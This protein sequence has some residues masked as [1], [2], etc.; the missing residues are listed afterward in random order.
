MN[1][2]EDY[3]DDDLDSLLDTIAKVAEEVAAATDDRFATTESII[4][5]IISAASTKNENFGL[6]GNFVFAGE[7]ID[8]DGNHH[9]MVLTSENLPEWVARGMLLSADEYIAAEAAL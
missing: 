3:Q 2:S 5:D 7:I 9:L 8:H 1:M 6:I 4:N